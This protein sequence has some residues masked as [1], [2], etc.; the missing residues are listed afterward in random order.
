MQDKGVAP[1][2]ATPGHTGPAMR[3]G[4]RGT[5]RLGTVCG[6]FHE[7]LCKVENGITFPDMALDLALDTGKGLEP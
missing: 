3:A 5:P 1:C 2:A 6:T 7:E 4:G